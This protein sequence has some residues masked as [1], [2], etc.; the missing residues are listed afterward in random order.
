[1]KKYKIIPEVRNDSGFH[2]ILKYGANSYESTNPTVNDFEV[3]NLMFESI[4]RHIKKDC[5][6]PPEWF[7]EILESEQFH[8]LTE[9]MEVD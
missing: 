9:V 8:D 1:M 5:N 4:K 3:L 6:V 2:I 7:E